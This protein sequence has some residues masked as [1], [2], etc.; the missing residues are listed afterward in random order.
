MCLDI[1]SLPKF[2]V[3]LYCPLVI[4][5]PILIW[6]QSELVKKAYRHNNEENSA[7]IITAVMSYI[8]II[9]VEIAYFYIIHILYKMITKETIVIEPVDSTEDLETQ[10]ERLRVNQAQREL[11]NAEMKREDAIYDSF[12]L[13]WMISLV[14][15]A[16]F[17]AKTVIFTSLFGALAYTL[18]YIVIL[19]LVMICVVI[20]FGISYIN[21]LLC[22]HSSSH[23]VQ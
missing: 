22:C 5:F 11:R 3:F 15:D 18:S 7:I 12:F 2:L 14:I 13:I 4:V 21:V 16:L 10:L 6:N 8:M 17:I 19:L 9:V 23:E 20:L 1:K